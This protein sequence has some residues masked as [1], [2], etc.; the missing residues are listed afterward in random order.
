MHP[1]TVVYLEH[2]GKLL[3]VD[4]NGVGPQDCVMG[5]QINSASIR[6]PTVD[7]VLQM[8]INWE[9]ERQTDVTFDGTTYTL[10]HG[11]PLID[12]PEHWTWKD[13]VVSDNAVHPLAREAVYRSIHR[14]VS[15]VMI[16][17]DEQQIL[18]V[19]V[20]R[21]F[22]KGYWGLPGGYMNHSEEPAEGCIRE[23]QEELGINIELDDRKPVITQRTFFRD[24]ISFMSFTYCGLWNGSIDELK[25]K[26]GEIAE[27][28][29]FSLP[30][31]IGNAASEFDRIALESFQ[32]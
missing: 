17:N 31:A 2:D 5:R 8:G 22:F 32:D 26:E 4:E 20:E 19:K 3:L 27:A 18:M 29:W 15:K 6:L 23:T 9:E 24:G 7:E 10:I 16:R 14:L 21:G 13:K 28:A 12:W 11:N 1:L 30:E 25:L